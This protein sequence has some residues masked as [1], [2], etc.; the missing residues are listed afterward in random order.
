MPALVKD[1]PA[2]QVRVTYQD[3]LDGVPFPS[4]TD[5]ADF[6]EWGWTTEQVIAWA[7]PRAHLYAPVPDPVAD[8]TN[9]RAG[10]LAEIRRLP[11]SSRISIVPTLSTPAPQGA[12]P[13]F[14]GDAPPFSD[15]ALALEF[16][17]RHHATM[18]YVAALGKWMI[19]DGKVWEADGTLRAF[20]LARDVCREAAESCNEGVRKSIASAKTR[21]AVESLAR[22]DRRHAGTIDQ[23]DTD[24]WVLNTP[25]G[26]VDLRTGAT[27]PHRA[28]DYMTKITAVAPGGA[29]PVWHDFLNRITAGDER[30]EAY[31][32]R[33]AGYALTGCTQES[34]LA[35]CYGTGA[36]GKSVFLNTLSGLL[37]DYH[38][39][40]PIETFTDSNGDRHPTELAMLRGARLVTATETEE[41]RRFAEARI[42]VLTGG[43]RISARFMRQ[44]FFEYQPQFKLIIA[45]NHRPGLRSVDEAIRRRFHLVPFEVTIPKAERD[46]ELFAKL[47]AE[48]PGVLEWAIRGCQEWQ[49]LGLA[50][51]EA[52]TKATA[53]YLDAE[54]AIANWI[55]ESC[56]RDPQGWASAAEL[57]ASWKAWADKAGEFVGS[58]KRFSQ[59]LEGRGI[60][61]RR[62]R[63]ARGFAGIS[64]KSP[65]QTEAY[66]QR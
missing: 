17:R 50:P 38:R 44:D 66:W 41:G 65:A 55:G 9:E 62:T 18:R 23:W 46:P 15:E 64:L 61:P 26:V 7:K 51:P 20:D 6:L 57:F 37:G 48:W 25:A 35:F 30:L 36:N 40:A 56:D 5:A 8:R 31:L 42:K 33:L 39:S 1:E 47:K 21:A 2:P 54:D 60:E 45:G 49:R 63:E 13:P 4:G 58:Q 32:Q 34:M 59:A 19:F 29:C 24:L 27:R 11:T 16:T 43:D 14:V 22:S 28:D 3:H 52:V 10:A 53:A 12:P